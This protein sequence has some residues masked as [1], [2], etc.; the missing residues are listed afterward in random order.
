MVKADV[1]SS[2]ACL[3]YIL[4]LAFPPFSVGGPLRVA[5]RIGSPSSRSCLKVVLSTLI[6]SNTQIG[7][8][9]DYYTRRQIFRNTAVLVL[10]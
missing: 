6:R 8:C 2:R 4:K 1:N 7:R 9:N 10:E 3:S 5:E